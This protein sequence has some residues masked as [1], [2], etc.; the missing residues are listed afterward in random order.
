MVTTARGLL[1]VSSFNV[2]AI[3]ADARGAVVEEMAAHN[4]FLSQYAA[5]FAKA[6]ASNLGAITL[7][8]T[9]LAV[10]AGGKTIETF[11]SIAG[12]TGTPTLDTASYRQGLASFRRAATASTQAV[13]ASP[14]VALDLATGFGTDDLIELAVKVDIRARLDTAQ[15]AIRLQTSTG[16]YF[17]V[18][19]ALLETYLGQSLI[20]NTWT[21]V[22]VPKGAFAVTGA[23]S[24]ASITELRFTS[25]AN[26]NG[27]LTCWFDDVRLVPLVLP[28]GS[29]ETALQNEISKIPVV[30]LEDLGA[31]QVRAKAFWN[32]S[33]IVGT[34]RL[35]GL[36]GNGGA[37]LAAIV[38]L[39]APLTKT[40]LLSLTVE[41]TVTTAGA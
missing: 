27:T 10:A 18:T 26:A 21:L 13:L 8:I 23:P 30:T 37:T 9:H 41:W 19:W 35:F 33:Q 3:L 2:R 40:N 17:A 6:L 29:A 25:A 1:V 20:D 4:A 15:E 12:W 38:A 16:N 39:P 31:G 28:S 24:W 34:H 11:E 22:A 14:T 5:F 32:T 36:Y 7:P